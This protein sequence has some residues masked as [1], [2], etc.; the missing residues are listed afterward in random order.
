MTSTANPFMD[1]LFTASRAMLDELARETQRWT[2]QGAAQATDAKA[3]VASFN[4]WLGVWEKAAGEVAQTLLR[5]PALLELGARTLDAQLAF[6]RA[7]LA[8]FGVGA[9]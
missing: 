1:P 4:R 8:A 6:S 5:D 2:G 7:A 9:R 3:P